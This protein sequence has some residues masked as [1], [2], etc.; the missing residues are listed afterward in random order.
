MIGTREHYDLLACFEREFSY[1]RLD[2]E[3]KEL[4][5][6]RCVYACGETNALY[7]AYVAGYALGKAQE[8]TR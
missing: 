2:R 6:E 1:L 5:K 7:L 4:W 3:P 8:A